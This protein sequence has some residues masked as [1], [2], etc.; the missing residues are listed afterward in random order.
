MKVIS[1]ILKSMIPLLILFGIS[2]TTSQTMDSSQADYSKISDQFSVKDFEAVKSF[3]L[4]KGNR[5]TYRNYD[6]NNPYYNFGKF[7]VYLGADTG[8]ANI[9]NDS[10]VSDFNE[11]TLKDDNQYYKILIVRK[12]DIDA[13]KKGILNGMDED[14]VY[15]VDAYQAGLDKNLD[16]LSSY[17]KLMKD[18]K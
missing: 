18:L 3:I 2:K 17:L 11:M 7:Q 1:I 16:V 12:G 10:K 15:F 14:E 5:K 8:Q 13:S 4:E 9:N 6:N